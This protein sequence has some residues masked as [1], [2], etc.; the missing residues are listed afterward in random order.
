MNKFVFSFALL[1]AITTM[2]QI[3][4]AAAANN[5]SWV[6]TNGSDAGPCTAA[7]PCATLQVAVNNTVIGGEVDCLSSGDYGPVTL[8]NSI[9]ID[10]GAGQ[11]GTI[12]QTASNTPAITLNLSSIGTVVLRNLSLN[13]LGTSGTSGI[14]TK[15]FP[16]GTLIVQ[17]CGIFG[18]GTGISFDPTNSRGILAISD[19]VVDNN[20]YGVGVGPNSGVIASVIINRV[21]IA[22]NNT[23]VLLEGPGTVAGTLR[24][25]IIAENSDEG[26][27]AATSQGVYF[28]IEESSI[29]D[30]LTAGVVTGTAGTNVGVGAST[31]SGNGIGLKENAGS[32]FSFGNNQMSTNGTNGS[33]TSTTPL[34]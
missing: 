9:T 26:I 22:T 12:T 17:H 25:S 27:T 28:T 24:Q 33:F 18:F 14:D 10:C 19:S 30:N 20:F 32:L 16:G 11:V 3:T 7:Q 4:P 6:S 21:E 34:Q 29:I 31:I 23:G 15:G 5:R 2:S 13:G 8:I 1:C